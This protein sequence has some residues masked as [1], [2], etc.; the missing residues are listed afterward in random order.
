MSIAVESEQTTAAAQN[1]N[2][3]LLE[4]LWYRRCAGTA[5]AP[6]VPTFH[7]FHEL[8]CSHHQDIHVYFLNLGGCRGSRWNFKVAE[9]GCCLESITIVTFDN[10]S[11]S[12]SLLIM[13][14]SLLTDRDTGSSRYIQY[15][16][17]LN[18]S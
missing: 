7:D 15:S 3:R 14:M 16:I 8:R 18:V 4:G 10:Q 5:V 17:V 13:Q 11:A 12:T 2:A 1:N 6:T 9:S